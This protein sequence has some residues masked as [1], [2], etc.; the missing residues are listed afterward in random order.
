MKKNRPFYWSGF[1]TTWICRPDLKLK[2]TLILV[3]CIIYQ[4]HANPDRAID[5][6]PTFTNDVLRQDQRQISG[7]VK[8]ENGETMPGVS[9]MIKG[10]TKATI[11]QVDGDFNIQVSDTDIL[12]FSFIGMQSQEIPVAGKSVLNV[13]M[14]SADMQLEG[15]AVVAYG[16]QKKVTITG[17]IS[18]VNSKELIEVP[19]ASVSNMLS[20][21]VSGLTTV[22]YSGQP[23][24]D[25]AQLY[26]R[27]IGTLTGSTPL[28]LVDGVERGF[29]Q[30]D[31]NEIADITVLK[32]AS[33]TAVF[34]VRG[35]NGV[36]LVTTRRGQEGRPKI[37]I[38]SSFS[39]QVP[40]KLG[41]YVNAKDYMTY[42]N[43]ANVNDG[44]GGIFSEDLLKIYDDPNRNKL[45]YPDTDWQEL[46]YNDYAPQNQHNVNI[47]GGT[48]RVKYFVSLGLFNQKGI[49]N[50]N[51]GLDYDGNFS[52]RRNN[53]RTNLDIDVTKSTLLSVNIGGRIEKRNEPQGY[54]DNF[55]NPIREANPLSAGLV[56]GK[57]IKGNDFYII[58]PQDGMDYYQRAVDNRITNI[59]N[60]D[61]KLRQELNFITK[62][63][64]VHVKGSYNSNYLYKKTRSMSR[65]SYTPWVR[66]DIPWLDAPATE[67]E[68]EQVILIKDGDFGEVSY[69][70]GYGKGRDFYVEMAVNY[71]RDFGKHHVS[72]LALYN[73][74]S[75]F[76]QSTYADLPLGY[77]G[78]VG[79]ATYDYNNRY[80][81]D[82]SIGYNG[83]EKFRRDK[84]Y[85]LFP[86]VSIG[87]VA[88][89]ESFLED[90]S[91]IQFLKLRASVGE[92]GADNIGRFL[93][94][95][96]AYFFGGGYIFGDVSGGHN[97]GGAYEGSINNKDVT[98]ETAIKQNY[99]IDMRF[100]DSR[101]S[102][103]ADYFMET[104][105]NI[106]ISRN[107]FPTFVAYTPPPVNMGKVENKG[108][109][110]NIKWDDKIS[111]F[112]YNVG[113][114]GSYSKNTVVFKD[115]VPNPDNPWTLA[116]GHPVGQPFGYK[117]LGF[118]Q[119][120]MLNNQGVDAKETQP[121]ISE[122]DCVYADI[123]GDGAIDN[124]D[125]VAIGYPN[126]PLFTASMN[127]GFEWKNLGMSMTWVGATK[128]SRVLEGV[129]REPTGPT[130]TRSLMQEQFDNRW[131]PETAETATLPRASLSSMTANSQVSSL[132]IKDADYL[133]LRNI[134]LSYKINI[135]ALKN[136]GVDNFK[137]FATGY[138]LLTFDKLGI[139]DPEIR[140]QGKP[141][142]PLMK[143]YSFGLNL[144]F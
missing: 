72:G 99:G 117:F 119:A 14:S 58:I 26:V 39:L 101:L 13:V 131:T 128:V 86:S 142:Y 69:S 9:V 70:D 52:Y 85:G 1:R 135:T 62:G 126:Y 67:E 17:A 73:A 116:T 96:D 144:S 84:R 49:F 100:L 23:G 47:S 103:S 22:Q 10:S 30:L 139:L 102:I 65:P 95:A 118:Y 125:K 137:V 33:A 138:N 2:L 143:V 66:K 92:V 82:V 48:K 81:F 36:I 60:L 129:L 55:F 87:W 140:T 105:D 37:S 8:D 12:I 134:T 111:N 78:L 43:E 50:G 94:Q 56:D 32:D 76:Y 57:Y 63:L 130:G 35:A 31:P 98:W 112:K 89:E 64:N 18:S 11:T 7:I 41:E 114:I 51:K 5:E 3:V 20:G 120:G 74:T 113:F 107:T 53:I 141:T 136:L 42:V 21:K 91:V 83:S 29:T 44:G 24:E 4:G 106:L 27:G 123:N 19:T 93:Y 34:G 6:T 71:K 46:L 16:T 79:R 104:R 38:T 88:T 68:G 40:T 28:V 80:L 124:N 54:N 115:E 97:P 110:L 90:N 133:R 15:V 25:N 77:V 122:G 121:A 127:F 45:L 75:K 132:W 109:E 108:T 61:F 59:L